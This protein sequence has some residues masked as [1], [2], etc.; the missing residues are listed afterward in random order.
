[1]MHRGSPRWPA[2]PQT[3]WQRYIVI[4]PSLYATEWDSRGPSNSRVCFYSH[5]FLCLWAIGGFS[6]SVALS[7]CLYKA[8]LDIFLP[9]FQIGSCVVFPSIFPVQWATA[10]AEFSHHP[11]HLWNMLL[12]QCL[13][14]WSMYGD[15]HNPW[16]LGKVRGAD[17]HNNAV[18]LYENCTWWGH[19]C[20]G[21]TEMTVSC[22]S[23][24]GI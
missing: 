3:Q 20:L 4:T 15:P 7:L 22:Q 14:P 23:W 24:R 2:A 11:S 8:T 21:C 10:K 5:C 6:T 12:F 9:T 17:G 16:E 19:I 18:M 13:A 1:M